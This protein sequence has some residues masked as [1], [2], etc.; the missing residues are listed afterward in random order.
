MPK[1]KKILKAS[2]AQSSSKKNPYPPIAS[3]P[4]K[5]KSV[6]RYRLEVLHEEKVLFLG[7]GESALC[8]PATGNFSFSASIAERNMRADHLT[9]TSFDSKDTLLEKYPDAEEHVQML[10]DLE[11]T[12]LYEID[13][14]RLSKTPVL[15]GKR[16][17]KIVFMFPH[18]GLGIKD[19]DQN[20]RANQM[21]IQRFL[22][23]SQ[24][25]LKDDGE[26]IVT[27]KTGLPYDSWNVR[28][29]G[30]QA[31]LVVSRSFEFVPADFAGY[32]HRRTLGYDKDKCAD[33]NQEITKSPPRS[34]IF[35]LRP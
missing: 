24:S 1:L 16:F 27:V 17:D 26:I 20:I 7:E 6:Y 3:E 2:Q 18:V 19:Q 21:L 8:L 22:E 28:E 31:G 12:V 13:A 14:T 30:K 32:R 11:A 29:L 4:Q 9:C 5:K 23:E 25:K 15:K 35:K 34:Y 10:L 33:D